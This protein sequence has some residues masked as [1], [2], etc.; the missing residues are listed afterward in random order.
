M[1]MRK[2][3][4]SKKWIFVLVGVFAIGLIFGYFI[5]KSFNTE[6]EYSFNGFTVKKTLMNTWKIKMVYQGNSFEVDFR[7][8]PRSLIVK[9]YKLPE[10]YDIL[11]RIEKINVISDP[12]LPAKYSLGMYDLIKVLR[13]IL[14][15][16]VE[17]GVS[18]EYA[19]MKV[20]NCTE[21]GV[22][23]TSNNETNIIHWADKCLVINATNADFAI[24]AADL[25]AYHYLGIIRND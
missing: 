10:N 1:A 6:E 20:L 25:L 24:E 13:V 17:I 9:D 19:D 7:V 4:R 2:K 18:R 12:D 11:L 15:K 5:F 8:D 3:K 21:Y 23:F 16:D 22:Y 14:G